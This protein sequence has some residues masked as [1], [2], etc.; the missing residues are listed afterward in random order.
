MV[1]VSAE[2]RK[3]ALEMTLGACDLCHDTVAGHDV[4]VLGSAVR[5]ESGSAEAALDAAVSQRDWLGAAR[6]CEF[7]GDADEVVYYAIRC[8]ASGAIGLKRVL[9][10]A[11]MWANDKVTSSEVLDPEASS[12]LLS[13]S[14]LE[15]ARG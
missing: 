11:E 7:R 2:D 10:P 4:A 6:W 3:R 15:W 13:I 8:P 14:S 9:S 5:T 1:H 12:Q